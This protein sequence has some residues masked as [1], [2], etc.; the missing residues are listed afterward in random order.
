MYFDQECWLCD[1]QYGITMG[2]GGS[3]SSAPTSQTV[4]NVNQPP[5]YQVQE[6]QAL[7]QQATALSAMPYPN[8]QAQLIAG[9]TPQQTQGMQQA[10]NA[11][12]AQMP[13][14]ASGQNYTDQAVGASSPYYQAAGQM[15]GNTMNVA[16]PYFQQSGNLAN[17]ALSASQ[18]YYNASSAATMAAQQPWNAQTAQQYMSP[19]AQAALAPQIQQLQLQQGQNANAI[20][21]QATMAGA[22]GG[23]QYGNEQALNNL[24]A[25]QSLNQLEQSGMNSAYNSGLSAYQGQQGIDINAGSNL[26]NIGNSL[27][28]NNLNAASTYGNIG[29]GLGG[30]NLNAAGQLGNVG[31]GLY[32]ANIGAAGQEN[33]LGSTAS[34]TGIAGATA[35]FNAGT[36]Q[37][38]LNQSQLTEAYQN[39]MNQAN[40]PLQMLNM[41]NS[42]LQAGNQYTVPT[43]NLAPNSA[44]AQNVGLFS[45]LAGG[46]GSLL[47]GG[48]KA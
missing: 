1:T 4:T 27:A 13:Y 5:E 44:T 25:N 22:F 33:T 3:S 35:N 7:N 15:A 28:S 9:L 16:S 24:Y 14:L 21:A 29:A 20:N 26:G 18:P 36:Q 30:L 48:G 45:E 37:Q 42:M 12:T 40:W 46:V 2:G 17:N 11:S 10:Q 34:N 43:A 23:Q 8:Y 39:F 31:Q 38:A 32:G 6:Q 19:Y 41:Q 47:N